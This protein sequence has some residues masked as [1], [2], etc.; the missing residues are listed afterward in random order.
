VDSVFKITP[1][2]NPV[3]QA[4]KDKAIKELNNFFAEARSMRVLLSCGFEERGGGSVRPIS[5][6]RAQIES[7]LSYALDNAKPEARARAFMWKLK[8][9][10][11]GS[12]DGNN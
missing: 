12:V 4:Y 7:A 6:D 1:L 10:R 8:V 11:N 5:K 9:L 2:D 3:L